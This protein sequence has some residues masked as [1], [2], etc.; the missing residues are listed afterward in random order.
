MYFAKIARHCFRCPAGADAFVSYITTF[1]VAIGMLYA[2]AFLVTLHLRSVEKSII[3]SKNR[4]ELNSTGPIAR[5]LLNWLQAT[6]LLSTVKLTPPQAVKDASIVAEYAQGFSANWFPIK[7]ALRWS[8]YDT[9][10]IELIY[11]I[12]AA[13]VPALFIIAFGPLRRIV[14]E[15]RSRF[16]H[17]ARLTTFERSEFVAQRRME[18]A[19]KQWEMRLQEIARASAR[20]SVRLPQDIH[21]QTSRMLMSEAADCDDEESDANA[22]ALLAVGAARGA[23]IGA[24]VRHPTR[25]LGEVIALMADAVGTMRTHVAFFEGGE[26][27]RYDAISWEKFDT[28]RDI[29]RF[30]ALAMAPRRFDVRAGF[31]ENISTRRIRLRINAKI[32]GP[33]LRRLAVEHGDVVRAEEVSTDGQ[34]IRIAGC[35]GTGWLPRYDLDGCPALRPT[36][37]S[38]VEITEHF[39]SLSSAPSAPEAHV[40]L[41]FAAEDEANSSIEHRFRCL[42]ALSPESGVGFDCLQ[43]ILPLEMSGLEVEKLLRLYDADG[44]GRLSLA[45]YRNA[46]AAICSKWR[47][48]QI[49]SHF[50]L[51]DVDCDGVLNEEELLP[52]LPLSVS[53][54]SLIK[55]MARFDKSGQQGVITLADYAALTR[56]IKRDDIITV[57]GACVC[58]CVLL[59]SF[60]VCSAFYISLCVSVSSHPSPLSLIMS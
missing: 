37:S 13:I 32:E 55:W 57:L 16:K 46:D 28:G 20:G 29:H 58:V 43:L 42:H 25:G 5:L 23:S 36:P 1:A 12:I 7:C 35:W 26:S 30:D 41:Q 33:Y 6:A 27:H 34:M 31:Y 9:F 44:D 15:M 38:R 49:F 14:M 52:L 8:Y 60:L 11:P 53:E 48:G 56:A 3:R 24:I 21:H 10:T 45:E 22:A 54:D 17:K 50:A 59:P 18:D 51:A 40:Q 2:I 39:T 4:D 19:A 47:F